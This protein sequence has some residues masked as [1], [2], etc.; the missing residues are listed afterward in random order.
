M[1]EDAGE[2][3]RQAA[4]SRELVLLEGAHAIKHAL[5]FGA[6]VRVIAAVDRAAA[7]GLLG[8]IAPD[9]VTAAAPL[10]AELPRSAVEAPRRPI[11]TGVAAVATRPAQHLPG[12]GTVVV[13]DHPRDLGN[14]GAVVRAAAAAGASAVLTCGPLDP[15]HPA[16]LRGSAGLHFALPVIATDLDAITGRPCLGFDAGG[17]RFDPAALPAGTALVFGNERN[18][19]GADARRRCDRLVSLPMRAGVSSLNL[20]TSVAAALMSWRL[21][22]GWDPQGPPS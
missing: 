11:P 18:G 3:L 8:E 16:A 14:V 20:A 1:T 9:V 5:R 10:I 12:D 7:L 17:D 22:T 15:W 4:D 2:L 21:V 19:L 6:D 13:L